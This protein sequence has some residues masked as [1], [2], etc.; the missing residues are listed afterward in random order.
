MRNFCVSM[1]IVPA[2]VRRCKLYIVPQFFCALKSSALLQSEENAVIFTRENIIAST[3][4]Q[5]VPGKH[6]SFHLTPS[7]PAAPYYLTSKFMVWSLILT[8]AVANTVSVVTRCFI[9]SGRGFFCFVFVV[10]LQITLVSSSC[11]L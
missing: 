3:C 9:N 4:R 8:E 6:P 2:S 11:L 7:I 5:Q 1:L 10:F